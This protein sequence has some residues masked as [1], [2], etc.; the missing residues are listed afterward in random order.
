MALQSS[1]QISLKQIA[2]E[3]SDGAPHSLTEFYK[4]GSLVNSSVSANSGV[5]TSGQITLTDFYG[6]QGTLWS[7]TI[8]VGSA[9]LSAPFGGGTIAVL[10]GYHDA[11]VGSSSATGG[12]GSANDNTV[13]FYSGATLASIFTYVANDGAS[14][15]HLDFNVEGTIANSGFTS[16]SV[17]GNTFNRTDAAHSQGNGLTTWRW[18]SIGSNPMGTTNGAT[19][20]IIFV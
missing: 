3:F 8:T 9:V 5:P 4:G 18:S 10:Y 13:D 20:Q 16:I 19:K 14:T 12:F 17:A 11:S 6:T 2:S 15:T 1:G 7:M